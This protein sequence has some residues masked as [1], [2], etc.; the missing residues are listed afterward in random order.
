MLGIVILTRLEISL[1]KFR[2]FII[3]FKNSLRKVKENTRR[4]DKHIVD[5]KFQEG[6]E[7]WLHISKERMQGEG[8]KLKPI[9]YGPFNIIKQ[10]GNNAL[11]LDLPSYIQMYSVVNV[12]KLRLYE[13]PSI[14]DP[15]SDVQIPSI[16]DFSP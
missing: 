8:Q 4:H 6:D 3:K 16:E 10:V 14:N 5:H 7:V 2:L 1:R 13:P 15:V 11:Q 12:E 9:L